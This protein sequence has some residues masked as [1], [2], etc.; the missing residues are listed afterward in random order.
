MVA[1]LDLPDEILLDI[2]LELP[3]SAVGK[4][5]C[6]MKRFNRLFSDDYYWQC[7]Y[8][9]EFTHTQGLK[10]W[11]QKYRTRVLKERID[12][13]YWILDIDTEEILGV[14]TNK[15]DAM[16]QFL[17]LVDDENPGDW[18]NTALHLYDGVVDEID[19]RGKYGNH[20]SDGRYPTLEDIYLLVSGQY[21]PHESTL[22]E[23]ASLCGLEV[24]KDALEQLINFYSEQGKIVKKTTI[25]MLRALGS[26]EPR[27][28][29]FFLH[30][31]MAEK[32]QKN[33]SVSEQY[34]LFIEDILC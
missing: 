6:T 7:R 20:I 9:R 5:S 27:L 32:A 21:V 25:Y 15:R 28:Y 26:M 8:K 16:K 14:F 1:I 3:L 19:T 11:K 18:I 31:K 30:R 4:L 22:R 13:I 33:I 10:D 17:S 29:G 12:K 2:G 24:T 34:K 23:C